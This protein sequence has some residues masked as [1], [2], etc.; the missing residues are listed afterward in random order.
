MEKI[1][2]CNYTNIITYSFT[3]QFRTQLSKIK[4]AEITK[5][6]L[7]VDVKTGIENLEDKLDK[8]DSVSVALCYNA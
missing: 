3:L 7:L 2:K 4:D 5:M 6:K 1:L 8:I